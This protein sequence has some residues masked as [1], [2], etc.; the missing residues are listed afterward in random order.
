MTKLSAINQMANKTKSSNLAHKPTM[1]KRGVSH[2]LGGKSLQARII[3][4]LCVV[5]VAALVSYEV[6]GPRFVLYHYSHVDP[7]ADADSAV[8]RGD[9]RLVAVQG[10]E[11][12]MPGAASIIGHG[13]A[14]MCAARIIP[15]TSDTII[16][17]VIRELNEVAWTYA[18]VYNVRL[19]SRATGGQCAPR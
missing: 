6:L 3:L 7:V 15:F 17:A 5:A 11:T 18:R 13:P 8:K 2:T 12:Y 19:L 14:L 16:N 1:Q 9:F 4:I 10:R